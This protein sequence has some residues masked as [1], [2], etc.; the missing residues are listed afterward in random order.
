MPPRP[1][2]VDWTTDFDHLDPQ[3]T[4]DP[5]PI[6]DEL[7]QKC[8]I[9]H[10]ERY[11]GVYLPTRYDDVRAI[12]YDT[13]HFSSRRIFVRQ[14]GPVTA[15]PPVTSDPP[16]HRAQ[17][18]ILM[19]AFTPSAVAV[20]E[21]RIRGI[22]RELAESCAARL[23]ATGQCDGARHY[24]QEIPVRV[25][26]HMLGI[27][28]TNGDLFRRW[29]HEFFDEGTADPQVAV[30]VTEEVTAFFADIIAERRASPGET[31]L[32]SFLLAARLDDQP[33]SDEHINGTLRLLLFAGIDTTWSA[34]GSCLWHLARH[35]E[36]CRRLVAEPSLIPRAVEEFLR[37]YAPVTMGREIIK[38]T[39]I[40]GCRFKEGEMVML[41]YPAANRDPAMFADP[42]RVML[43]RTKNQNRQAAFGLGIHRCVGAHLARLELT[44]AL[45]EWLRCIR[46]FVLAPGAEMEWS[47]GA[48]RGPRSLPFRPA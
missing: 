36:D 41:A 23:A 31:D 22:C 5:Y 42:E 37:V 44:V 25:T 3:W 29:L 4:E 1:P 48:V 6:W 34:L 10:T 15:A 2:V 21:P 33:L 12:A 14:G 8:P 19:P 38:E 27:A 32:V 7:R 17:R 16:E 18:M 40:A 11:S 46:E 39:E 43:D 20:L 26:A 28:E 30:R 9:A 35:A 45:E 13:E 47:A 24:A